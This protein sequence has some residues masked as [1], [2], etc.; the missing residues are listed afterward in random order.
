[1]PLFRDSM[2]GRDTRLCIWKITEHLE[3]LPI[4]RKLDMGDIKADSR[5]REVLAVYALLSYMLQRDDLII[6]H[7][8]TGRPTLPG[9]NLSISHT[10]GWAALVVSKSKTVAIDIEYMSD[11]VTKVADKFIR[12]D[13][14]RE[15]VHCQLVTWSAKETVYK[16]LNTENL[17]Y[18]EMRLKPFTECD[19]GQ[20]VV[21]DLK[22]AKTI[23]VNYEI[24]PDF[25]LTYSVEE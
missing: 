16:L 19:K 9:W 13:E 15:G 4:P 10:K 5:R 20:V 7:D 21:E 18:F 8:E 2:I 1:M 6:G 12:H 22:C 3:D 23:T 17:Q 11:R 24:T 25:V 14:D